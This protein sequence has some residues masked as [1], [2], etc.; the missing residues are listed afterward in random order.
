MRPLSIL[1]TDFELITWSG[2]KIVLRDFAL[3]L[4]ERGHMPVVYS[5]HL[6]KAAERFA[7]LGIPSVNDP[8]ALARPPDIIH[9]HHNIPT[10]MALATYPGVPAIAFCHSKLWPDIPLRFERI[11]R[12]VA[13]DFRRSDFLTREH[14]IDRNR[15]TILPNAIDLSRFPPRETPLPAKPRKALAFNKYPEHLPMLESAC[16]ARGIAFEAIGQGAKRPVENPEPFLRESDIVFAIDRCAMEAICVGAAVI[17]VEPRGMAG[18]VT[19]RRLN[20]LR[21]ANFGH[22]TLIHE[23]TSSAVGL[24]IDRYDAD[25]AAAVSA[26]YREVAGIEQA[27]DRLEDIYRD[28]LEVDLPPEW[29]EDDQA[30]LL[31]L[32]NRWPAPSGKDGF[33]ACQIRLQAIAANGG[34]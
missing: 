32:L 18:I 7:T 13:V 22:S 20:A 9:A 21:K 10:A 16:Q 14:H 3:K 33:A 2:S 11:H 1:M 31:A 25:D 34:P 24:E 23:V 6:G 29:T 8:A 5:P 28:A 30:G 27:V 26:A 19:S 17:L 12:H 15:V 4:I